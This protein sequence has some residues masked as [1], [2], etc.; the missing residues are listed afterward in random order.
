MK[1]WIN[2]LLYAGFAF[3]LLTA[4]SDF[5]NP[6]NQV[7]INGNDESAYPAPRTIPAQEPYPG[8]DS[9]FPN[10]DQTDNSVPYPSIDLPSKEGPVFNIDEPVLAGSIQVTGTGP[11]NVTI[12]LVDVTEMGMFLSETTINLDGKFVFDLQTPLIEFHAVGLQILDFSNTDYD[13][14]D[15]IYGDDY[16]DRPLI[17]ILLDMTSVIKE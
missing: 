15:F 10:T 2:Y 5:Q 6:D 9:T 3:S 7:V 12:S 4:C 8:I 1:K 14:E 11:A 13:Y 16:I 17:G